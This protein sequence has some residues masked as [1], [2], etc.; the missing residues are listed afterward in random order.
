M[1]LEKG[2]TVLGIRDDMSIRLVGYA[3]S[4][5]IHSKSYTS[6]RVA[7]N[8]EWYKKPTLYLLGEMA[9][10]GGPHFRGAE[11]GTGKESTIAMDDGGPVA[12]NGRAREADVRDCGHRPAESG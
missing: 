8:G 2:T 7:T 1:H 11:T 12:P 4:M 10:Y 5:Y 6:R 3:T 9:P